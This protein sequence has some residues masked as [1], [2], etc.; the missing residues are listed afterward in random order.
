[1]MR[2]SERTERRIHGFAYGRASVVDWWGPLLQMLHPPLGGAMGRV[3]R[4]GGGRSMSSSL[5]TVEVCISNV[6]DELDNHSHCHLI[7][8]M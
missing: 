3:A 1:M 8:T 7:D 6:E 2:R 5:L 4:G